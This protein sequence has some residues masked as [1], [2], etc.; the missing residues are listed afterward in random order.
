MQVRF[1]PGGHAIKYQGTAN[2]DETGDEIILQS[3]VTIYMSIES[4]HTHTTNSD[5]KLSY[6]EMFELSESLGVSVVAFTDHDAVINEDGL[7]FLETVR[8]S[9]TRWVSGIEISAAPPKE[10][11]EQG[12]G[13]GGLHIIGLF[14]D[15]KNSALQEHCKKAQAARIVRMQ[16]IVSNL[17]EMGFTLTEEDCLKASGGET[18]GRPHIVSAILSHPENQKVM[19]SLREQMRQDARRDE[20]IHLAYESMME[21]GEHQYPYALFL[22]HDAYRKAYVDVSYAPDLDET[23]A[24][25]RNAGGAAIIAHYFTVKKKMPMD[26]IEKLLKE[27]RIDGLETVY[28]LWHV[29]KSDENELGTEKAQLRT[30]IQK[31]GALETGG[32]DAHTE[33]DMRLYTENEAFSAPSAGMTEKIV[34]S[35]KVNAA[36]S[37]F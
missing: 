29:G 30:L 6:K 1:L 9:K 17:T 18:V 21:A 24:L 33:E 26:F 34:A 28:G 5:G 11:A 25:I 35:G 7:A 14:V 10:I 2:D 27:K 31:Y 4:L 8:G 23:V 20:D 22:S 32:P 36:N 15:P 12:L 13:K 16:T 37:S 3:Q 19:D